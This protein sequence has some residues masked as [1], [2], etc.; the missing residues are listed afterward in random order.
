MIHADYHSIVES[1]GR[2]NR[3][4]NPRNVFQDPFLSHVVHYGLLRS[5]AYSPAANFAFDKVSDVLVTGL[6]SPGGIL[7]DEPASDART[8]GPSLS[9]KLA[10]LLAMH[11]EHHPEAKL[12]VEEA[13]ATHF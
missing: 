12:S 4:G 1:D 6:V 11:L 9:Q 5:D 10:A 2:P 13:L 3:R 8:T 7:N